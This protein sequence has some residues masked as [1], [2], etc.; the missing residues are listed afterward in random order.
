MDFQKL[1]EK[2]LQNVKSV[3]LGVILEG[4]KIA[5]EAKEGYLAALH[6]VVLAHSAK[7]GAEAAG[8][9][10]EQAKK[11]LKGAVLQLH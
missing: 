2:A 11:V 10:V 9:T 3:D 6:Y 5:A 7:E 1:L 4:F 8:V